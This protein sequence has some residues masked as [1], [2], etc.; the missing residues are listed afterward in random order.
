MP[1]DYIE[2]TTQRLR[3][4]DEWQAKNPPESGVVRVVRDPHGAFWKRVMEKQS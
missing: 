4:M 1:T 2:L 3:A